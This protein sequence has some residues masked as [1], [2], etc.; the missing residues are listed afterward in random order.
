L[1]NGTIRTR[2]Q[3]AQTAAYTLELVASGTQ[4]EDVY[5][6]VDVQ[7]DGRKVGSLQL[8]QAGWRAYPLVLELTRGSHELALA[9]VNDRMIP[10]VADRNVQ[11]D[12]VVFYRIKTPHQGETR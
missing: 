5:P 6:L 11:M 9:F 4:V 1:A 7:V 2:I 8:T 12:K 10:G 3:V